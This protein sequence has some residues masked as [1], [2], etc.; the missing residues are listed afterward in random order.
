MRRN[1]WKDF[2]VGIEADFRR[3]Q[4]VAYLVLDQRGISQVF[5]VADGLCDMA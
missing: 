3:E 5:T 2:P 4:V 1:I